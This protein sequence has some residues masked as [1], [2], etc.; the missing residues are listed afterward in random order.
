MLKI[1]IIGMGHV[2][3]AMHDLFRHHAE[4]I[5]YDTRDEGDYP[6]HE[7]LGCDVAIICV[8]TP[9]GEDGSCDTSHLCWS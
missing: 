4:I 5:T 3:Q 1:A 8:D 2:G 6:E 9:M 7:L